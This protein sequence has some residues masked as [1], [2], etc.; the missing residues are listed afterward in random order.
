MDNDK[1]PPKA[2]RYTCAEYREEMILA[3][4]QRALNRKDLS[5]EERKELEQQI[6]E[7]EK[8]MGL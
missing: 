3:G 6:A 8:K 7:L 2:N 4:L 5:P 1:T